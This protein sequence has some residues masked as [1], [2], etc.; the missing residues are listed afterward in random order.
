M[1]LSHQ[2]SRFKKKTFPIT[3]IADRLQSPANIGALFRVCEAFGVAELLFYGSDPDFASTR[4]KRTARDTM[5]R[6]SHRVCHD[7]FSEIDRLKSEN[8]TVIAL[9]I[10]SNSIAIDSFQKEKDEK[11]ALI[12]GNERHGISEAILN[13]CNKVVHIT[14]YG[15]NSSMNVIQATSIALYS[16]TK[17]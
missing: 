11:I 9:E 5:N 15:T 1:Q 17:V 10:T 8:Y 13:L 16:L 2:T 3:V 14:M 6:V 12:I 7:I 4:L